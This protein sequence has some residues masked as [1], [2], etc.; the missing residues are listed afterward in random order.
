MTKVRPLTSELAHPNG[1]TMAGTITVARERIER[2]RR[3]RGEETRLRDMRG[4][5]ERCPRLLGTGPSAIEH[6]DILYD[7]RGLPH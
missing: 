1:D 3:I 2:A 6:S 4:I 7:D 5:A